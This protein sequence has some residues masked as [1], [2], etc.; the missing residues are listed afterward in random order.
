MFSQVIEIPDFKKFPY[1]EKKALIREQT[2]A[3]A[4][5][6]TDLSRAETNTNIRD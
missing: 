3:D 4:M 5:L 1:R 2:E 6:Q